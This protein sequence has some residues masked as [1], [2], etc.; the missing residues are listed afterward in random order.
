MSTTVKEN[1]L[2]EELSQTINMFLRLV[3]DKLTG[4]SK[5]IEI[6]NLRLAIANITGL[7]TEL[8]TKQELVTEET[9]EIPV[10]D[11]L[12][13]IGGSGLTMGTF[14]SDEH[15]DIIT[16]DGFYEATQVVNVDGIGRVYYALIFNTNEILL[17]D[18]GLWYRIYSTVWSTPRYIGGS[19]NNITVTYDEAATLIAGSLLSPGA[20]YKITGHGQ[21][22]GIVLTAATANEFETDGIRFGIIPKHYI[23]G[24]YDTNVWGGTWYATMASATV[25]AYYLY[26]GKV[27]RSVTGATGTA[28]A[29]ALDATNWLLIDPFTSWD[30]YTVK[31]FGV[32]YRFVANNTTNYPYG[33]IAKQWDEKGNEFGEDIEPADKFNVDYNDWNLAVDGGTFYGNKIRR[34]YGIRISDEYYFPFIFNNNG[35]GDIKNV[36]AVSYLI[37]TNTFAYYDENIPYI[38]SNG[39]ETTIAC[40]SIKGSLAGDIIYIVS[41][42]INAAIYDNVDVEIGLS[43]IDDSIS[44][45]NF[46][47]YMMSRSTIVYPMEDL[48]FN[49]HVYIRQSYEKSKIAAAFTIG[50]GTFTIP[51]GASYVDMTVVTGCTQATDRSNGIPVGTRTFTILYTG[52]YRLMFSASMSPLSYCI[53]EIQA[54]KNSTAIT[55]WYTKLYMASDDIQFNLP[56]FPVYLAAGDV[57]TIKYRHNDGGTMTFTNSLTNISLDYD[58]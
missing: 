28:T 45:C 58:N 34:C 38:S 3:T 40:N 22:I 49:D 50:A 32:K 10:F 7:Q 9:G 13:Q 41:S 8:D 35:F 51:T 17:S 18:N 20:K 56:N 24:T 14:D 25:D 42:E 11:A 21:D 36:T 16:D 4:E 43:K 29:W 46:N 6:E 39:S 12:G 2:N 30:Y 23:P 57:I 1:S 55:P 47:G 27:Y 37:H 52:W 31:T 5:L 48:T 15:L 19:F 33:Y 26:C 53:I 54:F 44:G